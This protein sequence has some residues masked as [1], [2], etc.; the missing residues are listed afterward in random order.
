M[1]WEGPI[2]KNRPRWQIWLPP[3]V[4][5]LAN[6]LGIS[7]AVGDANQQRRDREEAIINSSICIHGNVLRVRGNDAAG[8]GHDNDHGDRP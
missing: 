4:F 8:A 6:V 3:V 5:I 2:E 7:W 1:S